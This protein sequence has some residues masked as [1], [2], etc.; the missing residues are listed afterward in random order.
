MSLLLPELKMR[1]A[2]AI[3]IENPLKKIDTQVKT[4]FTVSIVTI[5]PP[6]PSRGFFVLFPYLEIYALIIFPNLGIV[7]H[8]IKNY[9]A[10][11]KFFYNKSKEVSKNGYSEIKTKEK[12][13]A[14]VL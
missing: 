13:T 14:F 8:F 7:K 9:C 3:P 4:N 10:F 5:S 6:R 12:R 2:T 11:W 1:F